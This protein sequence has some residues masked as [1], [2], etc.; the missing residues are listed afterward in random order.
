M[1]DFSARLEISEMGDPTNTKNKPALIIL[2]PHDDN[3]EQFLQ[4]YPELYEVCQIS[5]VAM[6][7]YL[8]LEQ[9]HGSGEVTQ[10]IAKIFMHETHGEYPTTIL[11]DR[12]PRGLV[13]TNRIARTA[14]RDLIDKEKNPDLTRKLF[15]EHEKVMLEKRRIM[16]PLAYNGGIFL[17][18]HTMAPFNRVTNA[19]LAPGNVDDYINSYIHARAEGG[20]RR[21]VDLITKADPFENAAD[22]R[23]TLELKKTF[24][25]KRIQWDENMPYTVPL[26]YGIVSAHN[27][28]HFNGI[29]IDISKGDL[30]TPNATDNEFDI[31]RPKIDPKKVEIIARAIVEAT[32]QRLKAEKE[33]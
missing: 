28:L 4:D 5:R 17:D 25:E 8:T 30:A 27:M 19:G 14:I 29:A 11:K 1:N 23:L 21:L 24:T 33:A 12:V 31:L 6:K 7:K 2:C 13:D 32:I 20:S 26:S 22:P 3:G 16:G 18:I 10:A 15:E 9:D